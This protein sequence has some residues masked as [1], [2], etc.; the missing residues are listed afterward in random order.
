M[1]NLKHILK[2]HTSTILTCIGGIGVIA[3]SIMSVKVTPKALLLLNKAEE[4]KG[5]C[6]TKFE[7]VKVAGSVY[8]PAIVTGAASMICIFGANALNKGQQASLA[9]AY[10]LIDTSYKSY[11]GKLKELY[12]EEAHEKI[13]DSI[14]VEK[15]KDT[16]IHSECLCTSCGLS[17]EERSGDTKLF[18][19]EYANR[20][21]E[22]TIE[23]VISAEYHLNRNF[24]IGGTA[25]LNDFYGFLGLELTDYG[26]T[27]G[28]S[29]YDDGMFWIDFNHR[30]VVMDDGLECYI[31]EMPFEPTADYENY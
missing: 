31:I 4:E 7:T 12:G 24:V 2:R 26:S 22:T 5:E 30:K 20:Y 1:N 11:K 18:Y 9:S 29:V 13:V 21:F 25:V 17:I 3:T 8:I 14:A 27:V 19:D 15:A 6:L 28:W 23:Q 10:A 16:Y